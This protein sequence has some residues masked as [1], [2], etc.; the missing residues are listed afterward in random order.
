M[1]PI[2]IKKI[3]HNVFCG[4]GVYLIDITDNIF[5]NFAHECESSER[6]LFLFLTGSTG[7]CWAA[8]VR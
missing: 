2:N 6:L 1:V 7:V 5:F 4:T 3:R 8:E